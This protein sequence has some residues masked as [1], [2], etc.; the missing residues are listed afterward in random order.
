METGTGGIEAVRAETGAASEV[1][2]ETGCWNQSWKIAVGF[3]GAGEVQI[4]EIVAVGIVVV[5]IGIVVVSGDPVEV[6][7]DPVVGFHQKMWM[8]CSFVENLC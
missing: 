5:G 3:A 8:G 1:V 4:V 2:V 7:E 6:A